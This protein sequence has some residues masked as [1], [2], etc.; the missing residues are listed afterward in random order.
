MSMYRVAFTESILGSQEFKAF[1]QIEMKMEVVPLGVSESGYMTK[2]QGLI[3]FT[4]T[5]LTNDDVDFE[6]LFKETF[7]FVAP[8]TTHAFAFEGRVTSARIT[9][10]GEIEI[11]FEGCGLDKVVR[12]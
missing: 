9:A 3:T 10:A 5:L 1:A 12:I 8:P 7:L 6:Q 4:V 11:I 2:T